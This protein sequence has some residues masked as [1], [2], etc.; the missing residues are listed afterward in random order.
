MIR[1]INDNDIVQVI[2][3]MY[4]V[5][6]DEGTAGY[7]HNQAVWIKNFMILYYKSKEVNDA[8]VFGYFEGDELKGFI[9]GDLFN[10]FYDDRLVAD[11]KDCIT[12]GKRGL[13]FTKL[14][15]A[16]L[17]HYQ[18]INVYDWRFDSIKKDPDNRD[19]LVEF[20]QKRYSTNNDIE[21]F[22]S[23]RGVQ[24]EIENADR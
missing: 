3:L 1:K 6:G 19:R 16:F 2:N 21:L 18:S 8:A 13:V 10:S 9:T 11:M 14:F 23:V 7:S 4:E 20:I 22:V 12:S 17:D 5:S 15:D 24:K